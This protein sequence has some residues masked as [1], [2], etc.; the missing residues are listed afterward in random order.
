MCTTYCN[1]QGIPYSCYIY[2]ITSYTLKNLLCCSLADGGPFGGSCQIHGPVPSS[3]PPSQSEDLIAESGS[4][5]DI[6]SPLLLRNPAYSHS[7]CP[8]EIH[9]TCFCVRFIAEHTKMLEDSTKV[10]ISQMAV[11]FVENGNTNFDT[12]NVLSLW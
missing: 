2:Q 1:I 5:A 7:K 10:R 12:N 8:P 9:K 6:K 4:S 3:I 11:I